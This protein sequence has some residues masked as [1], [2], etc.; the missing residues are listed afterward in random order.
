MTDYAELQKRCQRGA[1]NLNDANNLL[2]ECYAAIGELAAKA[3]SLKSLDD[4]Q[5]GFTGCVICGKYTNHGGLRCP[6]TL[7]SP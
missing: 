1:A 5:I 4:P 3:L 6:R 2:A 7:P